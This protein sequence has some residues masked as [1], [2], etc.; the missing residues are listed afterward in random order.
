M[1]RQQQ[2]ICNPLTPKNAMWQIHLKWHKNYNLFC[3]LV[4]SYLRRFDQ[5]LQQ[6][7]EQNSIKGRQGRAHA[8]REDAIKNVIERETEH[9]NTCGIGKPCL[10]QRHPVMDFL[11]YQFCNLSSLSSIAYLTLIWIICAVTWLN[12]GTVKLNDNQRMT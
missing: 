8:S 6:I 3:S 11:K 10:N 7:N 5:E 12:L 4:G 2:C 1:K 9:Y